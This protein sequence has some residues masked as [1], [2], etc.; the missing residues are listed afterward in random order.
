[1]KNNIQI[2]TTIAV[3]Y[4]LLFVTSF[5]LDLQIISISI[6]RRIL[7]IMLLITEF[8][9]GFLILKYLVKR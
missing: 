5:L 7:V 6:V 4:L 1:M 3:T 2:I 8:T 9:I